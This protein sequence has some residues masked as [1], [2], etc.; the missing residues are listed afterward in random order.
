M[1]LAHGRWGR[2][3]LVLAGS[4]H[5]IGFD[6]VVTYVIMMPYVSVY[7]C[8]CDACSKT[9]YLKKGSLDRSHIWYVGEPHWVQ[10]PYC[11]WWRS[12][13]IWGQQGSNCENLV[14][15]ISQEGKLGQISYLVCRRTTLSTRILLFLVEVKGHLGSTGTTLWKPC[16]QDIS[17][18][19]AWTYL[20]FGM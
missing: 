7:V 5:F 1:L 18:R 4:L 13:V 2:H 14:N 8:V 6:E 10:E 3:I 20:I 17:I 16:K 11:F 9:R 19:E 12:M 15:T